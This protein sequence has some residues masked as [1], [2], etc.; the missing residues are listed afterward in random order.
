MSQR[1]ALKTSRY[2][3]CYVIIEQL[4][5]NNPLKLFELFIIRKEF[6]G[7]IPWINSCLSARVFRY[8][9]E[10][11]IWWETNLINLNKQEWISDLENF[12]Q[13]FNL[14]L[15]AC[16]RRNLMRFKVFNW[17]DWYIWLKKGFEADG[18]IAAQPFNGLQ[19]IHTTKKQHRV[20]VV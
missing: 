2:R 6:Y 5:L 8:T 4:L 13:T 10:C 3:C 18:I 7:L 11:S 12:V 19:H 14:I 15:L 1:K 20:N 16:V 9:M 17:R